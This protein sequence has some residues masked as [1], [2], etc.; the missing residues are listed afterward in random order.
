MIVTTTHAQRLLGIDYGAA[1][2]GLSLSS[3]TLAMPYRVWEH[4]DDVLD[5]ISELIE[6]EQL[7]TVVV[8]IPVDAEGGDTATAESVRMF[9][10]QLKKQ[11]SIPITTISERYT[12]AQTKKMGIGKTDDAHAASLILQQFIDT[13]HVER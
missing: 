4:T 7:Q 13:Q 10:A 5:R 1:K 3:G 12:T 11:I 9:I 8:G 2:I 6:Q